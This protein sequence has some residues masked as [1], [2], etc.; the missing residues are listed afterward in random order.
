MCRFRLLLSLM[1]GLSLMTQGMEVAVAASSPMKM[2]MA[3]MAEM[4]MAAADHD[5]P[6]MDMDMSD[7]GG[8]AKCPAKC[9]D[10]KVCFDMSHCAQ[11][12]PALASHHLPAII[13]YSELNA[14]LMLAL[15]PAD[16]PPTS[17][18]RPPITFH[19]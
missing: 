6:C 8:P 1:L 5:M 4:N 18:L 14:P 9:C 3:P 2:Q 19:S 13:A 11:A 12:Q 15:A 7:Q 17:L 10:G 16:S